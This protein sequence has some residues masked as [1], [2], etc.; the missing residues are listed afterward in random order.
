MYLRWLFFLFLNSLVFCVNNELQVI[1]NVNGDSYKNFFQQCIKIKRN[2]L[3]NFELKIEDVFAEMGNLSKKELGFL[4]AEKKSGFKNLV[5]VGCCNNHKFLQFNESNNSILIS[6]DIH[7]VTVC[8]FNNRLFEW[9][10]NISVNKIVIKIG[11]KEIFTH[12]VNIKFSEIIRKNF[13]TGSIDN[14]IKNLLLT[15][16][17]SII[18]DFENKQFVNTKMTDF[19]FLHNN[20]GVSFSQYLFEVSENI[21]I[22]TVQIT[23]FYKIKFNVKYVAE[24]GFEL[25]E[26]NSNIISYDGDEYFKIPDDM[27]GESVKFYKNMTVYFYSQDQFKSKV[28]EKIHVNEYE[29]MFNCC[30]N[31]HLENSSGKLV[32]TLEDIDDNCT[33]VIQLS[34]YSDYVKSYLININVSNYEGY[35]ANKK[36]NNC[37]VVL[38]GDKPFNLE[39]VKQSLNDYG[40]NMFKIDKNF[41]KGFSYDKEVEHDRYNRVQFDSTN[42]HDSICIYVTLDKKYAIDNRIIIRKGSDSNTDN[43]KNQQ[44]GLSNPKCCSCCCQS[45]RNISKTPQGG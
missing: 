42:F 29:E 7:S 17:D 30:P 34:R 13:L 37:V 44:G 4:E 15:K 45:C 10:R 22:F 38:K 9:L 6:P 16:I 3:K 35:C 24:D 31:I 5:F 19:I 33:L 12:N 41:I 27:F 18:K 23:Y 20:K 39:D 40:L 43:N 25:R 11:D 28:F 21:K 32:K 2:P 14:S 26:Q 8:F 1:I 36:F